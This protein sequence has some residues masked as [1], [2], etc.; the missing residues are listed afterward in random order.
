MKQIT[1]GAPKIKFLT[2]KTRPL[3][4]LLNHEKNVEKEE[5]EYLLIEMDGLSP[6]H[7]K[8]NIFNKYKQLMKKNYPKLKIKIH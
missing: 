3:F 6:Y 8:I 4:L 2:P 5:E 1:P 7:N